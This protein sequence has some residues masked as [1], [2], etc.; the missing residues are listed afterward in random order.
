MGLL[1]NEEKLLKRLFQKRKNDLELAI[2]HALKV[3]ETQE[4][5]GHI[6]DDLTINVNKNRKEV[7]EL[8]RLEK[9]IFEELY[10]FAKTDTQKTA[11]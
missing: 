2:V 7:L 3:A 11:K 4:I 8:E 1:R 5:K 6:I 10:K 9:R